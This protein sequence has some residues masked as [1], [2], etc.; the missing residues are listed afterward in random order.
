MPPVLTPVS[1][2]MIRKVGAAARDSKP[3]ALALGHPQSRPTLRSTK[4]FVL[5]IIAPGRRAG[6][7]SAPGGP[8][9]VGPPGLQARPLGGGTSVGTEVLLAFKPFWPAGRR[10]LPCLLPPVDGQIEQPVAVVH[11]LDAAPRRPV[12]LE[13]A[14]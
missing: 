12:S 9:V 14:R 11:R 13:D 1:S 8:E 6:M 4:S 3:S 2:A 5:E 10:V 7:G